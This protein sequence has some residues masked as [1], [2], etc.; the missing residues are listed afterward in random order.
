MLPIF[1][2]PFI[3]KIVYRPQL[4]SGFRHSPPGGALVCICGKV[5]TVLGFVAAHLLAIWAFRHSGAVAGLLT[6]GAGCSLSLVGAGCYRVHLGK[7]RDK[8]RVLFHES[9]E[10][11]AL[12]FHLHL[13]SFELCWDCGADRSM[14]SPVGI[15][16]T[17]RDLLHLVTSTRSW[18]SFEI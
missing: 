8:I 1:K 6:F 14:L 9:L 7:G 4:M 10:L 2:N 18:I 17:G 11:F 13:H 5:E 15:L 12:C 16:V 3:I